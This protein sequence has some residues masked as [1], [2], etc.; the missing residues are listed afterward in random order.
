M[1]VDYLEVRAPLNQAA[2]L[3]KILELD[4]GR[5]RFVIMIAQAAP[6]ALAAVP[7]HL[8]LIWLTRQGVVR[9]IATSKSAA[10]GTVI[11]VAGPV[12]AETAEEAVVVVVEDSGVSVELF[13]SL[14]SPV[15]G[16]LLKNLFL[17]HQLPTM[18]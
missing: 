13:L 9:V 15:A 1:E 12:A 6:H 16:D 5:D 8:V 7:S 4:V 10:L 14:W 3:S 2:S 18:R 11:M 17:Q